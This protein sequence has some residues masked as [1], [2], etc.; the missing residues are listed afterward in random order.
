MSF[1]GAEWNYILETLLED[2]AKWR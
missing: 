2:C 1:I